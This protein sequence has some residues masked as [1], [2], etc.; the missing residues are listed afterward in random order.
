MA[1]KTKIC[2]IDVDKDSVTFLEEDHELYYGTMGYK[3]SMPANRLS[4]VPIQPNYTYPSNI[5]EYDV[6]I[7]DM[8]NT[9]V[10]GY[11]KEDYIPRNNETSNVPYI[12]CPL[13]VGL[14]NPIPCGADAFRRLIQSKKDRKPIIIVFQD[15]EV[16]IT[17]NWYSNRGHRDE[18]HSN[19][20]FIPRPYLHNLDGSQVRLHGNELSEYL[21][22]NRL[23]DVQFY[24]TFDCIEH[25]K[26]VPLLLNKNGECVSYLYDGEEALVIMLPQMKNKT[27]FM[28]MLFE[29]FLYECFSEYF[30]FVEEKNWI[31]HEAYM[32]PNEENLYGELNQA[33][34]EYEEKKAKIE[35]QIE[36]NR[37]KYQFLHSLLTA[38]GDELVKAVIEYL[39]WLGFES[40]IDN[41]A[42][43]EGDNEEDI[44][45][46]LGDKGL[47]ILEVKG[48]HGTSKDSECSQIDK[49][50]HRRERERKAFDVYALYVVNHQRGIEPLK[51]S[52]PPFL[53]KQISD[54]EDDERG[55]VT[56]WQLYNLYFDIERGVIDKAEARDALLE[57]GMVDFTPRGAIKLGVPYRYCQNNVICVELKGQNVAVG[58]EM[59]AYDGRNWHKAEVKS[60]Q[61]D[62]QDYESIAN[63]HVGFGLS[64]GLPEKKE[65]YVRKKGK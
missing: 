53:P 54:A 27:G 12:A 14:F 48:V 4:S 2:C 8:A 17:Y 33:K 3:V 29:D 34:K 36:A 20:D 56:T 10:E 40:V 7:V 13:S 25:S 9:R 59:Y 6:F 51:R 30:P 38:T 41:D 45:V 47:L 24:C 42:I 63:G 28:K 1:D 52:N 31:H 32:L 65:V 15:K 39:K 16:L 5:Q 35:T 22:K 37:E 49:I 19:F 43:T 62:K 50:K 64:E 18:T 46:D 23:D 55:L 11:V 60:I 21:F 57:Y 61:V 44:K 58:D 26:Y